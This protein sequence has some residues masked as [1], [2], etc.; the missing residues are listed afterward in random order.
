MGKGSSK[1]N[2]DDGL[3]GL[4]GCNYSG[5]YSAYY[6]NICMTACKD[7]KAG[8]V[9]ENYCDRF[10]SKPTEQSICKRSYVNGVK[11]SDIA[12]GGVG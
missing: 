2:N 12:D 8:Y 11:I 7:G 9:Q 1:H 3:A 10:A 6:N 4:C 5:Q